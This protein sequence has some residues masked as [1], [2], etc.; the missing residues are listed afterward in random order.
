[1]DLVRELLLRLE[2]M[3][4]QAGANYFIDWSDKMFV[5]E[6]VTLDEVVYHLRLIH[7]AG[8]TE[9]RNKQSIQFFSYSGLTWS[10]HDFLDSVRDAR[11]WRETKEVA[12]KAGGYTVEIL[13][14]A[15]KALIKNE[16][17]KLGLSI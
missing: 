14:G 17:A 3:P 2:A 6:G 1:M 16:L 4:L 10:G 13:V 11:I 7:E 15:A 12:K 5:V 9:P 8:F